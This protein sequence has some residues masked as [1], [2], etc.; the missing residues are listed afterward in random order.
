M[1]T[2]TR[3]ELHCVARTGKMPRRC[4]FAGLP[5]TSDAQRRVGQQPR[6]EAGMP[7]EKKRPHGVRK[8]T[9]QAS[10]RHGLNRFVDPRPQGGMPAWSARPNAAES[11]CDHAAGPKPHPRV[12][13]AEPPHAAPARRKS[14]AQQRAAKNKAG[15]GR[16]R[17][18]KTAT[19]ARRA[20][21]TSHGEHEGGPTPQDEVVRDQRAGGQQPALH[22]GSGRRGERAARH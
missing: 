18:C 5:P 4:W 11:E 21:R 14:C 12:R 8:R 16:R 13:G 15:L 19:Y 9:T 10:G 17:A 6:A 7:G 2:K 3:I 1:G 20:G 22:A